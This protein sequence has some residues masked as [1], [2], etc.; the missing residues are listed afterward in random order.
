MAVVWWL[1]ALAVP[2]LGSLEGETGAVRHLLQAEGG[3]EGVGI[4]G[5]VRGEG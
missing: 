4:L 3:Q 1:L 2:A 5:E